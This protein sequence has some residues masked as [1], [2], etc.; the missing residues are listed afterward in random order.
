MWNGIP[1]DI[2]NSSTVLTFKKK[3]KGYLLHQHLT[4]NTV[5]RKSSTYLL[6]LFLVDIVRCSLF[7]LLLFFF[8]LSA[9]RDF[10]DKDD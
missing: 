9:D 2:R 7:I 1:L 8:I 10:M 3:L 5:P 6:I 4:Q